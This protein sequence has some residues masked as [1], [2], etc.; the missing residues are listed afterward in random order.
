M[1]LPV[2][3]IKEQDEIQLHD[4]DDNGSMLMIRVMIGFRNWMV[5]MMVVG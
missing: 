2:P 3:H 4:G 5:M 1:S